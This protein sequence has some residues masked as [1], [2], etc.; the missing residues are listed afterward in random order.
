MWAMRSRVFSIVLLAAA[1]APAVARADAA[2]EVADGL[3]Y[4]TKWMPALRE[5]PASQFWTTHDPADACRKAI[6]KGKKAGLADDAKIYSSQFSGWDE[7]HYNAD[8]EAYLELGELGAVCDE[9][10]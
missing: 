7:A 8:H 6:A 3:E 10:A 4:V 1:V 5:S 9:Y 2:Q